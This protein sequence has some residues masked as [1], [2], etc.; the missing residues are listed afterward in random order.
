M[1]CWLLLACPNGSFAPRIGAWSAGILPADRRRLAGLAIATT[2][3]AGR[4]PALQ[5]SSKLRFEG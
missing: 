5:E 3:T 2:F 1:V 4:M